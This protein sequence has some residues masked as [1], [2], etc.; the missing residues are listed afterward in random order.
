MKNKTLSKEFLEATS[1]KDVL[2][3]KY[4]NG[5]RILD[6]L[7]SNGYCS[8]KP[9]KLYEYKGFY[10]V[11]AATIP[12]GSEEFYIQTSV[13]RYEKD[14]IVTYDSDEIFEKYGNKEIIENS[15]SITSNLRWKAIYEQVLRGIC[16]IPRYKTFKYQTFSSRLARN[17]MAISDCPF[18]MQFPFKLR[19]ETKQ[20]CKEYV[21]YVFS[22]FTNKD[23]FSFLDIDGKIDFRKVY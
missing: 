2:L 16:I 6:Y 1:N 14:K 8:L 7:S 22:C 20:M 13:F 10:I 18:D 3:E 5:M 21:K 4:Q 23:I 12:P 9:L 11:E 19:V 17:I 15:I